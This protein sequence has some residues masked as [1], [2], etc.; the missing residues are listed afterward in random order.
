MPIDP[1]A[2]SIQPTSPSPARPDMFEPPDAG[3]RH[4]VGTWLTHYVRSCPLP[5]D[6]PP[7]E[8]D[9]QAIG[10]RSCLYHSDLMRLVI[11]ENPPM[12]DEDT[13][14]Y[15][16]GGKHIEKICLR[17]ELPCYRLGSLYVSDFLLWAHWTQ[18]PLPEP[19]RI[20]SARVAKQANQIIRDL[21]LTRA[22][23]PLKD[24]INL[25]R[26]FPQEI[27][28]HPDSHEECL[29][30]ELFDF[31]KG[32]LIDTD[33]GI[34]RDDGGLDVRRDDFLLLLLEHGLTPV[35][36]IYDAAEALAQRLR[37][38]SALEEDADKSMDLTPPTDLWH[39]IA[40]YRLHFKLLRHVFP[41]MP[42]EELAEKVISFMT[43]E[44][45]VDA[46]WFT[47]RDKKTI[48]YAWTKGLKARDNQPGPKKG[49]GHPGKPAEQRTPTSN[50]K[51][52]AGRK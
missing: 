46:E 16:L 36:P 17:G 38:P 22:I 37:T 28:A 32:V 19:L 13:N 40:Q 29:D 15:W 25:Y 3:P 47:T 31:V 51:S 10:V 52:P 2:S 43:L 5:P 18:F 48:H 1:G 27:I 30:L 21:W 35:P 39:V 9:F 8:F 50:G 41:T 45:G 49:P 44:L 23:W 11:A 12:S 4:R 33:Q 14:E 7:L 42:K 26:G 24:A 20:R 34:L 6:Y